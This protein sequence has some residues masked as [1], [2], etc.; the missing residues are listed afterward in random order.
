MSDSSVLDV[1]EV[2]DVVDVD[3][4]VLGAVPL[5]RL[6]AEITSF[7]AHLTAAMCR[8]LL[9][10]G[11]YDRRRAYEQWECVSM[12]HWLN[13]H[14]GISISTAR[15][16]VAVARKLV[17][18]A[19]IR[20]SFGRGEVSFSRVRAI[21]RV[22]TPTNEHRWLD[23]ARNATGSQ[24]ERI[25]HDTIRAERVMNTAHNERIDTKRN[26]S[27]WIDDDGMYHLTGALPPDIGAL[28]VKLVKTHT[29]KNRDNGDDY[30]QRCVDGLGRVL[31]RARNNSIPKPHRQAATPLGI[32]LPMTTMMRRFGWTHRGHRS[33]P[34]CTATPTAPHESKTAHQSAPRWPTGSANMAMKSPPPTPARKS[35]TAVDARTSVVELHQSHSAATSTNATAAASSLD[36][37]SANA[38]THT[39]SAT[40]RT[41]AK[42]SDQTLCSC[43]RA[44]TVQSTVEA[45]PLPETPTGTTV[46]PAIAVIAVIAVPVSYSSI[47]TAE[48]PPHPP[49]RPAI[50]PESLPSTKQPASRRNPTPSSPE[51]AANDTTTNSRSGSP[52][53]TPTPAN[54]ATS[55]QRLRGNV[56]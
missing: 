4:V 35:V 55:D 8:W 36:A 39:T 50:Q 41:T 22:A 29:A 43:V 32:A 27:W 34:S 24:I 7:A 42:R 51:D 16:H 31:A 18:L 38:A 44:T 19:A 54:H 56:P 6:E 52:P 10:V 3:P 47:P 15:Q 33:S 17:E 49:T 14:A 26:L 48:P 5:E 25:V 23:L 37:D 13:V 28:L 2:L 11:E 21:C 30:A 20:E 45:G 9:L 40:T 46:I 53:T 1:V 12:A